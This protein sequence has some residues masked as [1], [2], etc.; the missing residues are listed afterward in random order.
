MAQQYTAYCVRCKKKVPVQNP[1]VV[2]LK[3]GR[4][5]VEGTCP[6]CGGKVYVFIK[7]TE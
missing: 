7:S 5:A 4:K 6:Y 1:K 3:N 2:T